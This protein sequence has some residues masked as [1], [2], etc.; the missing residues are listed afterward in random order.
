MPLKHKCLILTL[1][2]GSFFLIGLLLFLARTPKAARAD[3][4][5]WFVTPTGSGNCSQAS[6]CSLQ[7]ALSKARDGDS[8]Y[9]AAGTYT[10]TGGAVITITR[11]IALYGGWNGSRTGLPVRDPNANPSTID[12]QGARRGVYVS[13]GATVLLDGLHIARGAHTFQGA[14]LYARNARLTLRRV[15]IHDNLIDVYDVP[16]TTTYGGGAT[17]E[18]GTLLVE[19]STFRSNSVWAQRTCYG[20]GLAILDVVS[21]TVSDCLFQDND[22]WH[23]SGLYFGSTPANR[24]TLL[25]R[26]SVFL[27]NGRGRSPGR[28]HGGYAGA[29]RIENAIARIEGNTFSDNSANNDY[30]TLAVF[31]SEL[32]LA[33]N[34]FWN[35]E[36]ARASALYLFSVS[37]FTVVNNIIADNRSLHYW[38]PDNSALY[39]RSGSGQLLHNTIARNANARGVQ[40]SVGATVTLANTILVSHTVGIFVAA[41]STASLEGTLWG[42]GAWANGTDWAG[43]GTI[44]VGAVNVWGDP[45]FLDPAGGNYHIGPG[46]AAINVGVNAGVTADIDGDPR[47]L[48]A[49][50]DIGA[51][52]CRVR[53]R[54]LPLAL[55]NR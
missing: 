43:E 40:V 16:D 46:S 32:S 21:A 12:G 34:T 11:S 9:L 2:V 5:S 45:R 3:P 48:G 54:Y 31:S 37:P 23:G 1:A 33:G 38:L 26:D 52:E 44:N 51:D 29:A 41:G 6:P 18:G 35:N 25:L 4:G 10:G 15:N 22:A 55:R 42:S 24:G 50:Y 20:G 49:G 53:T 17:V 19:S 8:I 14:G 36:C 27:G 7:A 39:V 28:A 30:G 47:P 13:S